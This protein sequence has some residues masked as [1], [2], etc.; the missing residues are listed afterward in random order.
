LHQGA[1]VYR[2]K[3]Q[4]RTRQ[5]EKEHWFSGDE[6]FAVTRE[7]R[8]AV[9]RQQPLPFVVGLVNDRLSEWTTAALIRA[10]SRLPLAATRSARGLQRISAPVACVYADPTWLLAELASMKWSPA[11]TY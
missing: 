6:A 5:E 10:H 9:D 1:A 7:Q 8:G 11:W 2:A 3:E 4:K